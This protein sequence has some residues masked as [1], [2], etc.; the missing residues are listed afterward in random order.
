M[1]AVYVYI[2]LIEKKNTPPPL[3]Q[4]EFNPLLLGFKQFLSSDWDEIWCIDYFWVIFVTF[5]FFFLKFL[6]T[7]TPPSFPQVWE[8]FLQLIWIKFGIKLISGWHTDFC[9]F[10]SQIPQTSSP[11]WINFIPPIIPPVLNTFPL[12]AFLFKKILWFHFW[13]SF[14]FLFKKKFFSLIVEM[15]LVLLVYSNDVFINN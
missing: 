12:F 7:P 14:V 9:I 4:P 10:F 6:S 5:T 8:H 1:D 3:I 15:I 13:I 11:I 2:F